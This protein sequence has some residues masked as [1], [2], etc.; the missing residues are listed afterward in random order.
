MKSKYGFG[1]TLNLTFDTALQRVTE[2]LQREGFGVLTAI[3]VQ[4]MLKKKLNA[5]TSSSPFNRPRFYRPGGGSFDLREPRSPRRESRSGW[6]VR[7]H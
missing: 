4:A 6:F 3:D 2:E 7:R 1:K 5:E